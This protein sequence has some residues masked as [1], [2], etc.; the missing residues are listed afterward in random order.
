MGRHVPGR[1]LKWDGT[2]WTSLGLALTAG[3]EINSLAVFDDG[4]GPQLYAA[5]RFTEI[6]NV[7]MVNVA[8]WDGKQWLSVGDPHLETW[9]EIERLKVLDDGSG[10]ALYAL[11]GS[12]LQKWDG[13]VWKRYLPIPG[14]VVAAEIFPG[15]DGKPTLHIGGELPFSVGDP[16]VI[17]RKNIARWVAPPA[18]GCKSADF[19]GDGAI[20]QADLGILLAAYNCPGPGC[21]GD[22]DGDG[23]TDQA[24]L[25]I[26]LANFGQ[27]CG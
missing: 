1:V 18:P 27:K 13:Q 7:P 17:I 5:G 10:P 11:G 19:D 21:Q 3:G 23:D 20:T 4:A 16:P 2:A 15:P 25:G 9:D 26:L 6:N 14:P 12:V 22:A 8:R 24:D